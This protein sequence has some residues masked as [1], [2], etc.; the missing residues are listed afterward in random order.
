MCNNVSKER[1]CI[2]WLKKDFDLDDRLHSFGNGSQP[3]VHS[4]ALG[5]HGIS[6]T[7]REGVTESY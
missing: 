3:G 7:Y 1:I 4:V 6:Q 5:V 2:F